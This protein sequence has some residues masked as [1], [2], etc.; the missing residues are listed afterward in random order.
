MTSVTTVPIY[1]TVV[2]VIGDNS[3]TNILHKKKYLLLLN[4]ACKKMKIFDMY[5]ETRINIYKIFIPIP[6]VKHNANPVWYTW[7][8]FTVETLLLFFFSLI[9]SL[10]KQTK[11]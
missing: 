3:N 6:N 11:Q 4:Q 10:S 7:L 8:F 5:L 1:G 2:T 9:K